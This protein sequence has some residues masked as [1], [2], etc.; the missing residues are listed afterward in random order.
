MIKRIKKIQD[1]LTK[2]WEKDLLTVESDGLV[3][4]GAVIQKDD[5]GG[6]VLKACIE[7][8]EIDLSDALKEIMAEIGKSSLKPPTHAILLDS[9]VFTTIVHLPVNPGNPLIYKEMQELVRWELEPYMVHRQLRQLGSILVGRGYLQ[10]NDVDRIITAMEEEKDG[11]VA[12]PDTK[13]IPRFGEVAQSMGLISREQLEESLMLQHRSRYDEG[14][15]VSGWT[16]L[17]EKPLNGRWQWLVS[18]LTVSYKD[19]AVKSFEDA[20]LTLHAVYPNVGTA[21]ANLDSQSCKTSGVFEFQAGSLSYKRFEAGQ[22]VNTRFHFIN[23]LDNLF[24]SCAEFKENDVED[25]MIAGRWPDIEKAADYI[26]DCT[27]LSCQKLSVEIEASTVNGSESCAYAGMTGAFRHF[28]KLASAKSAVYVPASIPSPPL[29]QHKYF[30]YGAVLAIAA[31]LFTS[32]GIMHRSKRSF[33][34]GIVEAV[35]EK[36]KIESEAKLL[37]KQLALLNKKKVFLSKELPRRRALIPDLLDIFQSVIPEEIMLNSFYEDLA[38]VI[39][40]EGRGLSVR[41]IQMF[42][43]D[44]SGRLTGMKLDSKAYPVQQKKGRIQSEGYSFKF[45][46]ITEYES[47]NN[48]VQ[49]KTRSLP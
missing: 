2:K 22:V 10:N 35:Q 15:P 38:G 13:K 46:L 36:E 9:H 26:F 17:T 40:I 7:S 20:G 47:A 30:R 24:H 49:V 5:N 3:I 19:Y 28:E 31:L 1:I 27:G 8:S 34:T 25:V 42:K 44:V 48:T 29:T 11:D 16:S 39:H 18:G 23:D 14:E 4:R 37:R 21:G 12:T 43:L 6:C 45:D 41:S 33:R 32:I